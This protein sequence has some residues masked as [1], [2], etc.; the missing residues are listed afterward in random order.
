MAYDPTS[1]W[2]K[3]TVLKGKVLDIQNP[4]FLQR[5]ALDETYTIPR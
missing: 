1:P 4:V 5:S 3:T 2:K